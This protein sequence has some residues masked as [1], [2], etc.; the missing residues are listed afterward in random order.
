[1]RKWLYKLGILSGVWT[2]LRAIWEVIGHLGNLQT[3]WDIVKD[4]P[5]I[6]RWFALVVSS[7]WFPL[8]LS[9]MCLVAWLLLTRR[10]HRK[11]KKERVDATRTIE[12]E[13]R[14]SLP[15]SAANTPRLAAEIWDETLS[16]WRQADELIKRWANGNPSPPLQQTIE[17][18]ARFE[19]FA[20]D[21]MSLEQLK[22]VFNPL[23]DFD[24]RHSVPTA[25]NATSEIREAW[26][27]L[28]LY[29]MHLQS[30]M[31]DDLRR[32]PPTPPAPPRHVSFKERLENSIIHLP[33]I[34]QESRKRQEAQVSDLVDRSLAA[35]RENPNMFPLYALQIGGAGSLETEQQF[36]NACEALHQRH[37]PHPLK[38][39]RDVKIDW[40]RFIRFANQE[41]ISFSSDVA[42]YDCLQRFY[43]S[44]LSAEQP[45]RQDSVNH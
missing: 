13:R 27:K 19:S 22:I 39:F 36:L 11:E 2:V 4:W 45:D 5:E 43:A 20:R 38:S 7:W 3:A 23:E 33:V 42:V 32:P 10:A 8:L 28:S 40:V 9:I 37:V 31:R 14:H 35:I 15:I 30:F 16:L 34:G 21:N 18:T 17:W 6:L 44:P 1:M 41:E 25:I 12:E 26:Q 24:F 29:E